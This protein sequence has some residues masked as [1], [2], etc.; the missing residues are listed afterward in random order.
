MRSPLSSRLVGL[1]GR[2][3]DEA[4][5]SGSGHTDDGNGLSVSAEWTDSKRAGYSVVRI[6]VSQDGVCKFSYDDY[7]TECKE[8]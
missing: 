8:C 2:A 1:I 3:I 7:G 5:Y 6:T 4:F